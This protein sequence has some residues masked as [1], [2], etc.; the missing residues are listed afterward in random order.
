VGIALAPVEE[1]EPLEHR[2][3][4]PRVARFDGHQILELDPILDPIRKDPRF[5]QLVAQRPRR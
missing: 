1:A 3:R 5:A 4:D 2:K